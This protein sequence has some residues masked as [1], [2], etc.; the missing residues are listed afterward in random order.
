MK[1]IIAVS[2]MHVGSTSGLIG[3]R[4]IVVEQGEYKPNKYQK[5]LRKY[6]KHFWTEYV[7]E[8]TAN[9]EKRIVV[10]NGDVV[11]GVHHKSVNI[12]SNS[13][14]VQERAAIEIIDEIDTICQV[15]IDEKYLV[16][17]TEAHTGAYGEC[18]ERIGAATGCQVNEVGEHGSYQW[19]LD[20]DGMIFQFAHHIGTT[21]SA[22]YETSAPMRELVASLVEAA[23][24]KQPLPDIVVRSHR[25][26]FVEVPLPS[27]EGR[28]RC[29]ITPAWQLRTPFTERIDRMRMPHIGGV[30]FL[31][32]KGTVQVREKIYPLPGP[33]AKKI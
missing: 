1:A 13:L 19:W 9:A 10:F 12:I 18:E 4:V 8:I 32:E 27:L 33:K 16:K 20:V 26:R 5:T 30:I 2:D 22:A 11:D 17:G 3:E 29:V 21:S 15:K 7:P 31:V 24:W 28:I 25:H 14:Q 23:Q 6:W